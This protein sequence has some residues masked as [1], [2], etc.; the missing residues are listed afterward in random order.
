MLQC[1]T[2]ECPGGLG[3]PSL[4]PFIPSPPLHLVLFL[5]THVRA[6]WRKARF[7]SQKPASVPAAQVLTLVLRLFTPLPP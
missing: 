6:L 5:G 1:D 7:S 4:L 2:G 3:R